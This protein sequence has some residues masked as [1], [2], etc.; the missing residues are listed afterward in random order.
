MQK[1]NHSPNSISETKFKVAINGYAPLE[2]DTML[3]EVIDDYLAFEQ[4]IKILKEEI[5]NLKERIK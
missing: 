5:K 1:K 3:D 4:E 2:V